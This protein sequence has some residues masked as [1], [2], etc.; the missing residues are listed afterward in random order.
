M[1]ENEI[2]IT[3]RGVDDK[4]RGAAGITQTVFQE[5]DIQQIMNNPGR[6]TKEGIDKKISLWKRSANR[7]TEIKYKTMKARCKEIAPSGI[8]EDGRVIL[9][10]DAEGKPKWLDDAPI[11]PIKEKKIEK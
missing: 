10:R 9:S 11:A 8:T 6:L 2:D 7:H 1:V 4:G 3:P 5:T